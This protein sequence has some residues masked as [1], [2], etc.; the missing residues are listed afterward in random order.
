M[1]EAAIIFAVYV[2]GVVTSKNIRRFFLKFRSDPRA[3]IQ[4][5]ID[6]LNAVKAR[7]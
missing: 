2:L 4:S 7:F 3:T 6:S 1:L 5:E